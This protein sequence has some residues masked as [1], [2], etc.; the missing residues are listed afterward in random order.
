[1]KQQKI[2]IQRDVFDALELSAL[3]FGG[4]GGGSLRGYGEAPLCIIGLARFLDGQPLLYEQNGG[5]VAAELNRAFSA[6]CEWDVT[7]K[8]DRV[9]AKGVLPYSRVPFATW[10][11]RLNVVRGDA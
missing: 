3:V 1:M 8:S 9:G 5:E 4:V 6:S 11:K 10:C 7:V 2:T